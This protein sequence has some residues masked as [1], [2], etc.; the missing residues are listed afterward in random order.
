MFDPYHKWLGIPPKDQPPNHYRLLGVDL[1]E[2]DPDVIDAGGSESIGQH[3]RPGPL[4]KI[5][6]GP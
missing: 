4:F 6:S 1:F 3:N 2:S 5:V